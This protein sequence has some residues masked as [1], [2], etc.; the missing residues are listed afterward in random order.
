MPFSS[1]VV[2]E[3]SAFALSRS[4]YRRLETGRQPASLLH[5]LLGLV[6]VARDDVVL[7]RLVLF[8]LDAQGLAFVVDQFHAQLAE[9]S[10]LLGVGGPV[11]EFILRADV[12]VDLAEVVGQFAG[13]AGKVAGPTGDAR[14]GAHLI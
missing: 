13:E 14:K 2:S 7:Q 1:L 8:V 4:P 3:E 9:S 11:H 6:T 12:L 5:F 10:V